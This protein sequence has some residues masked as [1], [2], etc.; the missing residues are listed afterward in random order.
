MFEKSENISQHLPDC[1]N[2][3]IHWC[4][5]P[6]AKHGQAKAVQMFA[7]KHLKNQIILV[8]IFQLQKNWKEFRKKY[9]HWCTPPRAK[10]GQAKL[11]E[12]LKSK[13]HSHWSLP[14]SHCKAATCQRALLVGAG[15]QTNY[16]LP[17]PQSGDHLHYNFSLF[18]HWIKQGDTRIR[19]SDQIPVS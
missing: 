6:R 18:F 5:P 10:H 11:V 17:Q 15:P 16:L 2:S 9:I 8:S 12:S 19:I 14:C 4:T 7:K 1:F 13:V 3:H